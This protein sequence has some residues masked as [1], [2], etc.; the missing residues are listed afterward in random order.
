[1][2]PFENNIIIFIGPDNS[3]KTTIAKKL[4]KELD[5]SYFKNSLEQYSFRKNDFSALLEIG[6]PLT[7]SLIHQSKLK[8]S[9]I[10]LDRFTPCE[11]AYS[12]TYN[13]TTNE[14]LIWQID[15]DLY[16]LNGYIIYCYK[17]IY[18]NFS[19]HLIKSSE[20][21]TIKY[22]YEEYLKQT[23]VPYLKLNT[24]DQNLENQINQIKQFLL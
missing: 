5:V 3:G 2:H 19:D 14:K 7:L 21:G 22:Y 23:I 12:K 18:E 20:L 11:Y 24:T 16:S 10:I 17:D 8:N 15:K 4:A 9:V 13:R 6:A 1:M